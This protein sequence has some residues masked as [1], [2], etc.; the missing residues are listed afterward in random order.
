VSVQRSKFLSLVLRHDPSRIGIALDP[1]GWIS[2]DELLAAC[3]SHGAPMTRA[4]LEHIVATND[5]Q[6]FALSPDGLR[7]RASQGHSIDVELGYTPST[8]PELLFHGTVADSLTAIRADGLRPMSRHAVHLSPDQATASRVGGRRGKP[9]VL[10][11]RALDMHRAGHTFQVSA[12]NVWLTDLVPPA[13][14]TF[15]PRLSNGGDRRAIARDTLAACEA[16]GYDNVDLA[17][18]IADAVSATHTVDLRLRTPIPADRTTT[19]EVTDE[20]TVAAI[21]RLA[22]PHLGALNFASAKNPGGGFL[23]GAQ[24]Q[25]ESLARASALYP[26]LL[27]CNDTFYAPN[28]ANPSPLYLDL[29][30]LSPAVPFFRDD[31]GAWLPSPVLASI[32]TCPA[33]NA[34]ALRQQRSSLDDLPDVLHR[35]AELVLRAA[36]SLSIR[37][38]VLGAWGAGVFGNDPALVASAF[39]AQLTGLYKRAFDRVTFAILDTKG[40]TITAF[41]DRF[42]G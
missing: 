42:A 27:T 2:V 40:D 18:L 16:G 29:A 10:T 8:P 39:H 17:P 12:N 26:C 25:E 5:K 15:P 34:S 4:E 22:S 23:N 41:R 24:A 30:I 32:I 1:S 3:A 9:I 33:P 14:I 19:I 6:R 21:L 11:V 7:I 20:T 13:F 37:T 28:R 38:L 31:A 35:R 36:C